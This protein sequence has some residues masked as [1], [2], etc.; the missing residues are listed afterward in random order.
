MIKPI[1]LV[2]LMELANS[3]V[4]YL[5]LEKG[6]QELDMLYQRFS[7]SGIIQHCLILLFSP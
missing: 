6:V 3:T 5:S 2:D 7:V 1:S 4:L